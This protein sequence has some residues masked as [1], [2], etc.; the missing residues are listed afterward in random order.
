MLLVM[1]AGDASTRWS[2]GRQAGL[3]QPWLSRHRLHMLAVVGLL[4]VIGGVLVILG[5]VSWLVAGDSV[6][7]LKGKDQADALNS[8]RQT[9]LGA[10]AGV[11]VFASLAY[12]AR[13]YGL[14]RRGQVTERFRSAVEQLASPEPEIRIGGIYSLEHVLAESPQDHMAVVSVL[15]AYIRNHTDAAPGRPGILPEDHN[16]DR[17]A[18][19]WGTQPSQDVQAAV[20]VLARRPHRHEPRRLDLRGAVLIGLTL[21][22]FEF[23]TAP[24]LSPM[25]LTSADLRGADLRG[26]DFRRTILNGADLRRACLVHARLAGVA[27]HGADMRQTLLTDADLREADLGAADL[28]DATGLT[29]GQLATAFIDAETSLPESLA[30]DPWVAARLADCSAWR[31]HETHGWSVPPPTHRPG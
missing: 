10:F 29:A 30:A 31:S 15:A 14:S 12:T 24:R 21:R 13:T 25:F 2:T 11:T 6:R 28:R 5:P 22:S 1:G 16:A 26:T 7:S 8:V 17:P 3:E 18:P 27:L 20:D 4:G 23:T 9:V 19:P